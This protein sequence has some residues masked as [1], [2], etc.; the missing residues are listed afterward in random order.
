MNTKTEKYYADDAFIAIPKALVISD[1]YKHMSSHACILYGLMRDRMR[2]SE[3]NGWKDKN[4]KTYIFYKL[5]EICQS[6]GCSREKALKTVNELCESGLINKNKTGLGKPVMYYVNAPEAVCKTENR[7]SAVQ[8]TE[9]L[10]NGISRYCE[11]DSNNKEN[12]NNKESNN[13]LL[14]CDEEEI[15]EN[16]D[17]DILIET[18]NKD[19][20][21]ALVGIMLEALS[22]KS[23][24]IRIGTEV[25]S[26]E[27]VARQLMQIDSEHISYVLE[28]LYTNKSEIRDIRAYMLKLLYYAPMTMKLYYSAMYN[29]NINS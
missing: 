8:E 19:D 16:I 21:D 10:K 6:L 4:G 1:K 17:Y 5:N 15:K 26:Y 24:N 13:Y 20:V 22:S 14:F 2:L 27:D 29:K 9:C 11:T 25:H 18:E 28:L 3:M 12:N 23:G 7:R